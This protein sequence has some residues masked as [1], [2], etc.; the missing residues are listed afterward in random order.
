MSIFTIILEDN[1]KGV[2]V[3]A[4][5]THTEEQ[6]LSGNTTTIATTIGTQ[7]AE[8]ILERL[9]DIG[10]ATQTIDQSTLRH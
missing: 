8:H 6:M 5:A 1:D 2:L 9:T 7:I 10:R 3:K 4:Y